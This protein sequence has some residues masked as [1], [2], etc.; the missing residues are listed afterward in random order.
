MIKWL[1]CKFIGH[2]LDSGVEY[3]E[4]GME[5]NKALGNAIVPQIPYIFMR[6]IQAIESTKKGDTDGTK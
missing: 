1:I 4:N 5:R 3:C 6:I 2:S